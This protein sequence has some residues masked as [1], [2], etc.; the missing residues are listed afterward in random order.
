MLTGPM[1]RPTHWFAG[2]L[3][4]AAVQAGDLY[5]W[6]DEEG[7]WHFGDRP[8]PAGQDFQTFEVPAEPGRMVSMRREGPQHLP[9]YVF[10]NHVWGPLELELSVTDAINLRSDP[11]LP[12]R[13]ILPPQ[14]DTRGA[15]LR[16]ADPRLGFQYRLRYA[17]V[18]GPPSTRIPDDLDFYP[19]FPLG[20]EFPVSQGIDDNDTHNRPDSRYAVDI[21]MPEGT[22]VLAAR[23]GT[24]MDMEDDFHGG[25][26]QDERYMDRANFVRILHEDGSMGLYAHLQPNSARIYPGARVPAGT[27]IA[28]SGNTGYSS[29]P[30]LH[31][32][33]QLNTGMSLESL[34]FRFRQRDGRAITPDRRLILGGVLPSL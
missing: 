7:V 27:W 18:P 10:F 13:L 21:A 33:V 20:M 29:G 3:I 16:A 34:P 14:A 24:V 11:P 22:P 15:T 9:S 1:R 5:K 28:N 17:M 25:G 26:K 23:S 19:P 4:S 31:F 30:H 6:Q 2:L 8:P 12:L 32:A